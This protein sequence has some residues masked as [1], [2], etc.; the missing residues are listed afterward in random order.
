MRTCV[1]CEQKRAKYD[2]ARETKFKEKI[3]KKLRG[4]SDLNKGCFKVRNNE[5]VK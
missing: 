5:K 1:H 2:V 3:K 4:K